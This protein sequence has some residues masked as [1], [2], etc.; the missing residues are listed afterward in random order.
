M[1]H[2]FSPPFLKR[3]SVY[4][5]AMFLPLGD[6]LDPILIPNKRDK[7][8][9]VADINITGAVFA[10][11]DDTLKPGILHRMVLHRDR[12]PPFAA[13]LR[14]AFRDSPARRHTVMFEPQS[15]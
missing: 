15:K 14:Q 13:L 3:M 1:S 9:G 12:K 2:A 11:G 8:P 5:P 7:G 6:D 4:V 10:F